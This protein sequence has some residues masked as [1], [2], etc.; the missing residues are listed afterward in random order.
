MFNTPQDLLYIVLSFCVL[1]FTVFLC[2]LLYQAARVLKNANEIIE[3]V[4]NKL[5]LIS[6]AVEFIRKKV[7]NVSDHM[8]SVSKFFTG[9]IGTMVM[10]KLTSQLEKKIS[11]EDGGKKKKAKKK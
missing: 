8:G 7:D 3:N 5:E 9:T 1:W 2:W 11:G 10:N 6:D 4:T